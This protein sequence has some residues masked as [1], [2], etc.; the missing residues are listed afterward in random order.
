MGEDLLAEDDEA[1][2]E[3]YKHCIKDLC[4]KK[5]RVVNAH[6]KRIKSKLIMQQ[7]S[8]NRCQEKKDMLKII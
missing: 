6:D 5:N 2:P 1:Q 8:L 7:V 3:E 4:A